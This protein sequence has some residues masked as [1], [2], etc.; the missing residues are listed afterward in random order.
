MIEPPATEGEGH[1]SDAGVGSVQDYLHDLLARLSPH[2]AGTLASYIPELSKADPTH[3][4]IVL[5]T[6]DG[7]VYAVGDSDVSFSIQSISKPFVYGHVLATKGR[8]YVLQRI[9]VEPTGDSFNSIVLDQ[10][11]N[12]PFNP[13]VNAGAIAAAEM[14]D[15][16]D[17]AQRTAQLST[18]F[19]A[20][21]GR[22]LSIDEAVFRSEKQTGHRNRAIGYMMLSSGM[23][24]RDPE[25]VL[26]LYFRQCSIRVTC[27]DLSVMAATLANGG[28][29]PLSGASV[30]ADHYVAD[31]L[32]VMNTCGM[33][34]Y[35][36]QWS[37]EIGLP[38]KSGVSGGLIAV[39]PGQLGIAVYSPPLDA[40]GNSVRAIDVCRDLSKTYG[41]HVFRAFP[42]TGV[43]VRREIYGDHLRSKRRRT[44][45]Q[46]ARLDRDGHR[47]CT[48]EAQ[49]EL[50]FGTAERLAR[51]AQAIAATSDFIILDVGRVYAADQAAIDLIAGLAK[52]LSATF[53][54]A[55]LALKSLQ[56]GLSRAGV[57]VFSSVDL[58]LDYCEDAL[59]GETE[60][61]E[62]A[63]SEIDIF[64]GLTPGQLESLTTIAERFVF[65]PGQKIVGV[66]EE[67]DRFFAIVGG[68]AAV[69]DAKN[70][71][72]DGS[73]IA[74]VGP[75]A[76]FGEIALLDACH[77]TA[78]V[79]AQ[80]DVTCYGFSGSAVRALGAEDP[81]LLTVMLRNM[82]LELSERLRRASGEVQAFET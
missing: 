11:S 80:D 25:D 41:L 6:V 82:A 42:S 20:Y 28:L 50:Y 67:A 3:F 58:A 34:N 39:V 24:T 54:V 52:D 62:I 57:R 36:G 63:L 35:A 9:G 16:D 60:T 4:A 23:L 69:Y 10:S 32:T 76:C 33:Y 45:D 56:D 14:I 17:E 55:N 40:L 37:Y 21:A 7:Q 22:A 46:E 74:A 47:I 79:I 61:A 73:R 18:I 31:V 30:L 19:D 12:R 72:S 71:A 48:I 53:I 26:D 59:L 38:A 5:T 27:R 13:M 49:G 70:P 81:D 15:G 68:T 43:A 2:T 1:E 75:G 44:R 66:G 64:K 77:R 8:D 29:N 65:A 51:R 78:D